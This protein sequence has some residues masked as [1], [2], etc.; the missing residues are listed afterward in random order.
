MMAHVDDRARRFFIMTHFP[1]LR[2]IAFS[3]AGLNS[4]WGEI[5]TPE[6]AAKRSTSKIVVLY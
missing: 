1:R 2:R 5:F 3:W 6:Y 4:L